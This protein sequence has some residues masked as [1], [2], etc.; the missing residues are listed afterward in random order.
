MMRQDDSS[1]N[2]LRFK[3]NIMLMKPVAKM[4]H[5]GML[6]MNLVSEDRARA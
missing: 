6:A 1:N 3:A 4:F 5:S 2:D